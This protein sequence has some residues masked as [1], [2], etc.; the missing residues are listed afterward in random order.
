MKTHLTGLLLTVVATALLAQVPPPAAPPAAGKSPA[1]KVEPKLINPLPGSA[2]STVTNNA[3]GAPTRPPNTT[4]PEA[5]PALP[6]PAGTTTATPAAVNTNRP[7]VPNVNALPGVST[8][9]GATGTNAITRPAPG[10]KDDDDE[11]F[12]PDQLLD[13]A[14]T[15]FQAAPLDQVLEVYSRLTGRTVLKPATLPAAQIT[16]KAQSKLTVKETLQALD[17]VLS[18]NGIAVIPTG[19]K[20]LIVVPVAQQNQEGAAFNQMD[21]KDLPEAGQ[22]ITTIVQVKN[23]KPSEVAPA[24]QPFQKSATAV[25]PID[26]TSTLILRDNA[27]NIK[28]MLEVLEKIDVALPSDEEFKVIPVNYALAADVAQVLGSL[29]ASGPSGG[30]SATGSRTGSTSAR[31]TGTTSPFGG[32]PGIPGV[33]GAGAATP[34]GTQPGINPA[35]PGA[36]Q[37][38]T[39][40]TAFQTRLNQI[41]SNITSGRAVSA[42]LLGEAKIIPYERSNSLLVLANKT[43]LKMLEK[44]LQQIDIPQQQV[45]I[46]AL[47]FETDLTHSLDVNFG[48][49]QAQ[50]KFG[51]NFRGGGGV[52]SIINF[53]TNTTA[54]GA[55]VVAT[56]GFGYLAQLGANWAAAVQLLE[57]DSKT[58]VLSRP[59]IQTSHAEAANIFSGGTTPYVTG[60]ISGTGFGTQQQIQQLQIGINM[61]VLPLITSDGLVVLD[62]NQTIEGENGTVQIDANL[63]V[64][65]TVRHTAQA[66]V[67]VKD[68]ETIILGG[69]IRTAKTKSKSGVPVL[70]DI[71]GLGAL[72]SSTS[73][74]PTRK[75]LMVLLRPTVL[76]TPELASLRAHAERQNSATMRGVE[77]TVREQ[78][79]LQN[80]KL[81][82]EEI[83]AMRRLMKQYPKGQIPVP[84]SVLPAPATPA[85]PAPETKGSTDFLDLP[86]TVTP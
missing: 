49:V 62:I 43:E 8:G 78:E 65:K 36:A 15:Q 44:L 23:A 21:S 82:Q 86:K 32:A 53:S 14:L 69:L 16:L 11:R 12:L 58:E 50:K 60:S 63:K 13:Q 20:F 27:I 75:E 19:E 17:S 74:S 41:V 83:E 45:L 33:G 31:R 52:N 85:K 57:S 79:I 61:S 46:E 56:G 28:R 34:F 71:P 29:T 26:A 47:I 9:T 10:G 68:G 4:A 24:L 51:A 80:K 76:K 42:P 73:E 59:R 48:T 64:P 54:L 2:T 18:L 67:A 30:A 37:P 84:D 38:G 3:I 40:Q 77:Q 55:G 81:E 25:Q 72:F 70:K 6:L 35:T 22:Y 66:K 39:A 5:L 7:P 1:I